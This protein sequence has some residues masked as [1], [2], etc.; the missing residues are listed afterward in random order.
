MAIEITHLSRIK[1]AS[2]PF[3]GGVLEALL[4]DDVS[5]D[6]PDTETGQ[7][8]LTY[9]DGVLINNFV[10]AWTSLGG[11]GVSNMFG[12][13]SSLVKVFGLL[14]ERAAAIEDY[15]TNKLHNEIPIMS[16]KVGEFDDLDVITFSNLVDIYRDIYG[17]DSEEF[18]S[19]WTPE[20]QELVEKNVYIRNVL[21]KIA[22]MIRTGFNEAYHENVADSIVDLIRASK[23]IRSD[24]T[25]SGPTMSSVED[26]FRIVRD[27]LAIQPLNGPK[28][29]VEMNGD[30]P[31][32]LK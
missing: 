15:I 23:H 10:L 26:L 30:T 5:G 2:I 18:K 17:E 22:Q 32:I 13:A 4:V 28:P 24:E 31:I 1:N 11:N 21:A 16:T 9:K 3:C 12:S 29:S 8:I 6:A 19:R 27:K 14:P 20:I 7:R 25:I